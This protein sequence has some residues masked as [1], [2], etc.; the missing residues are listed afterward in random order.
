MLSEDGIIE[1]RGCLVSITPEF[2]KKY[3][4][5]NE[6]IKEVKR[7]FPSWDVRGFVIDEGCE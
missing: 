4:K 2:A 7:R 5:A 3:G 6:I 1:L